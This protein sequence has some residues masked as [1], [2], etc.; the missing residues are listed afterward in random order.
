[1]SRARARRVGPIGHTH[2]ADVCDWQPGGVWGQT[3]Q[4]DEPLDLLGSKRLLDPGAVRAP[5]Y[6]DQDL[7]RVSENWLA[8]AGTGLTAATTGSA[9]AVLGLVTVDTTRERRSS[10]KNDGDHRGGRTDAATEPP[11]RKPTN[12]DAP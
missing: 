5:A 12:V 2:T 11:P 6:T 9:L 7:R 3:R 8:T 4:R 1:M 10:T